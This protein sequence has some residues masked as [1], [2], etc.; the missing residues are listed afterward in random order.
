MSVFSFAQEEFLVVKDVLKK[1]QKKP[2]SSLVIENKEDKLFSIFIDDSETMNAYMYR[3]V[4]GSQQYIG[5]IQSERLPKWY[6][7][8]VGYTIKGKQTRLF[9]RHDNGKKFETVLFDFEHKRSL[10]SEFD[11][12]L[13][14]Q[15]YIESYSKGDHLYIFTASTKENSINVYDFTH[16][17]SSNVEQKKIDKQ[18][19]DKL[20]K[21]QNLYSIMNGTNPSYLIPISKI[22]Q[23]TPV[24]LKLASQANKMYTSDDGVIFTLDYNKETTCSITLDYPNFDPIIDT[25]DKPTLPEYFGYEVGNSYLLNNTIYHIIVNSDHLKLSVSDTESKTLIKEY[26]LSKDES[27]SFKNTPIIQEG[28]RFENYRILESTKQFLRKLNYSD[29]GFVVNP[30]LNGYKFIVGGVVE[31]KNSGAPTLPGFGGISGGIGNISV[32]V[33]AVPAFNSYNSYVRTKSTRIEG[34]FDSEFNHQEGEI[35]PNVF[36]RIKE[37]SDTLKPI[38][39][40][41]LNYEENMLYASYNKKN[42]TYTIYSFER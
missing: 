17:G 6:K 19:K 10:I 1:N 33:S 37:H 20:G 11:F 41:V 2:I 22:K 32:L 31:I 18:F 30:S 38:A 24:S 26:M 5:K 35:M 14:K 29:Y 13:N 39:E 21:S 28:G 15:V 7:E 25:Y 12:K 4:N 34:L 8:I 9:F 36:D 27:I 16:S 23:G 40:C 42:K 3:I